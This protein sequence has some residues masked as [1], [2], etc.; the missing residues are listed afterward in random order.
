MTVVL[1]AKMAAPCVSDRVHVPHPTETAV[2][3]VNYNQEGEGFEGWLATVATEDE[4]QEGCGSLE[5][6]NG[7]FIE[8]ADGIND[9]LF[10]L[11]V[12]ARQLG[13]R[14]A[15]IIDLTDDPS[16]YDISEL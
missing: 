13:F 5:L 15:Q 1:D 9:V 8:S 11:K 3:Y 16:R 4:S 6:P 2:I 10:V 12:Q 7:E 14:Y